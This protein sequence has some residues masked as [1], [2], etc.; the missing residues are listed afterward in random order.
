MTPEI[1]A[2]RLAAA[3]PTRQDVR[4]CNR[5]FLKRSGANGWNSTNKVDSGFPQAW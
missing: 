1:A 5:L 4:A 2:D 3:A